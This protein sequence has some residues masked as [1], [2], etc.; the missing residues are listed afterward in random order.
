MGK[1]FIFEYITDIYC[2]CENR[3][4]LQCNT[5]ILQHH[6]CHG[7]Y[8]SGNRYQ[9]LPPIGFIVSFTLSCSSADKKIQ[10]WNLW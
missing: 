10:L 6:S 3:K 2:L 7:L 5:F 4:T 9:S 1:V 8:K